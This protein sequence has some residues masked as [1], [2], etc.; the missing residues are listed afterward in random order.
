MLG[1]TSGKTNMDNFALKD[2][3]FIAGLKLLPYPPK[4]EK[5]AGDDKKKSRT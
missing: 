4:G 2:Y 3:R 1:K 5:L